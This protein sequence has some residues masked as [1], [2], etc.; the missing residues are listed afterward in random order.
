MWSTT[1]NPNNRLVKKVLTRMVES[2]D[3]FFFAIIPNQSVT[4]VL[5]LCS[6]PV[7]GWPD[8]SPGLFGLRSI[9]VAPI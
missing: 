2:G 9:Q 5:Q 6:H 4:E 7:I 8:A 3:Y 1:F